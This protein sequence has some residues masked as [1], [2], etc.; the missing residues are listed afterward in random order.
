MA[1]HLHK[2]R[3]GIELLGDNRRRP[4]EEGAQRPAEMGGMVGRPAHHVDVVLGPAPERH[5]ALHAAG[6]TGGRSARAAVDHA[7]GSG[8]GARGVEHQL[9]RSSAVPVG[10][11]CGRSELRLVVVA[12]DEDAESERL[13]R[14]AELGDHGLVADHDGY[15]GVGQDVR[16]F[17][18]P[19]VP[20]DREERGIDHGG[21]RG[22]FEDL[23]AVGQDGSH[24]PAR[25][26]T[27]HRQGGSEPERALL[28]LGVGARDLAKDDGGTIR[29]FRSMARHPPHRT[30]GTFCHRRR[31]YR[32]PPLGGA[33]SLARSGERRRDHGC[34]GRADWK[35]GPGGMPPIV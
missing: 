14:R 34:R 28:Q 7:L 35:R 21:G 25:T 16:E 6:P 26:G 13:H 5:L 19:E 15:T 18:R 3:P 10:Q 32:S 20:V 27:A 30:R 23:D 24:R 1:S 22:H 29:T 33:R 2:P 12:H 17:V 31:D 8:R 4:D 11:R 9:R